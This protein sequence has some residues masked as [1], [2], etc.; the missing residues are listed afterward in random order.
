MHSTHSLVHRDLK[1]GNILIDLATSRPIIADLG[2]VK[3]LENADGFVSESK[4]TRIYLPPESILL[5]HYTFRSDI[6]Q[7]G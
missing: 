4:A 3:K 1:P 7:V 5:K 2:S 6:Y